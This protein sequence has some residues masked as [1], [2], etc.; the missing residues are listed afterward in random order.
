M[1]N[2]NQKPR[3]HQQALG[4]CAGAQKSE[5]GGGGVA[6]PQL[7][8]RLAAIKAKA[9]HVYDGPWL[10]D[11]LWLVEQVERLREFAKECEGVGYVR[12]YCPEMMNARPCLPC[13]AKEA[14]ADD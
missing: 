2:E 14:L 4:A 9:P 8:Q 3:Q 1:N 10:A 12:C 11:V 7:S 5:T 13:R 6:V